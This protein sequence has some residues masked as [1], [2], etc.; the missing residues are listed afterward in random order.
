MGVTAGRG[1][2]C[3]PPLPP[4]ARVFLLV[5]P[6]VRFS[7]KREVCRVGLVDRAVR[8]RRGA[9]ICELTKTY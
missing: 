5:V 6:L 8:G 7:D 4:G 3:G 1:Y 2:M 9:V